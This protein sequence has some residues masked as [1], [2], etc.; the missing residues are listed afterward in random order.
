MELKSDK[1]SFVLS[2]P[3]IICAL[4]RGAG[5]VARALREGWCGGMRQ[6]QN[7]I[8]PD[9]TTYFGFAPLTEAELDASDTRIGSLLEIAIEGIRGEVEHCK[10]KYGS[11]RIGVVIGSSNST[12]EEFTQRQDRIDM[13]FPAKYIAA[14][15]E[16][17]GPG[18]VVSTACSSSAKVFASARHLLEAGICDA[19]ITGG[20]DAATRI[21]TGGFAALEAL[22]PRLTHPLSLTRDGINLGEGAAL[23]VMTRESENANGKICL[24][25]VGESSDAYHLTAPDPEGRGAE[26]AMRKALADAALAPGEIDY[27]NLH[28]T[29]TTYNDSMECA[30]VRKVFGDGA[31]CSSSKMMTGHTLGA[32]GAIEVALCYLAISDG[33]FAPPHATDGIDKEMAPFEVP[34]IGNAVK[35]S[36]ALSNSFAFG[37]SNAAVIIGRKQE[38]GAEQ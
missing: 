10:A 5:E 2:S 24:L 6:I 15:L 21:V 31:C 23:F 29:G 37:G 13:A 14:R 34:Q 3:S 11:A 19:V 7:P 36:T 33:G 16:V 4:G 20:A 22:S 35:I 32:A 17:K 25:G 12:M 1:C 38:S 9:E 27:I 30:A 26:E 28:G 8:V 18:W